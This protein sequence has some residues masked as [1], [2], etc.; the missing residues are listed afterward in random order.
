MRFIV[1]ALGQG[2]DAMHVLRQHH[3]GIDVK[4]PLPPGASHRL[5]QRL[6]ISHQQID[7]RSSRLTAKE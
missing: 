6:D 5:A 7:R 3:P 1:D 4:G 2:D